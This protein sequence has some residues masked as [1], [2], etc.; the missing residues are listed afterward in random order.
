LKELP[1]EHSILLVSPHGMGKS[2]V[3]RQVADSLGIGFYDLRLSQC[4]VGDVKGMPVI[5]HETKSFKF[6]KPEWWP[7]DPKSSGILFLDEINR[8][9]TDVQQAVFELVLDR[10]L[11]GEALPDGWRI[12][13]AINGD[14][15]YQVNEM[16]PAFYDRF[17]VLEFS[18]TV[19]EWILW[20]EKNDIHRS[21]I[22]F[23]SDS[24]DFLDPPKAMQPGIVYPS[25]RSWDKFNSAMKAKGLWD[26]KLADKITR[27]ALG[28]LGRGA[29]I[30]FTEY[31]L[32][33]FKLVGAQE[34]LNDF[35]KVVNDLNK[36]KGDPS[37]MATIARSLG[38]MISE[39][40]AE[41]SEEQLNN[42]K[43]AVRFFPREVASSIWMEAGRSL[44]IRRQL[45]EL[46]N[47][48]PEFMSYVSQLYTG[49]RG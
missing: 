48:D 33:D 10:K 21:I 42:F 14:D 17:Y 39:I 25:R 19:Y 9:V 46:R 22:Q 37:A 31:F 6:Y 36:M 11:D 8:A 1:L 29:A 45:G 28:F 43:K 44:S 7:R 32:K 2:S 41:L 15:R 20:A 12:V 24:P 38:T 40:E 4:E 5:N 35:D 16:D 18:P 26:S 13:S 34:I 23:I 49:R 27:V 3:V 47:T 30:R